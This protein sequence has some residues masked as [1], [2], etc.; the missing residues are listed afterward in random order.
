MH[1]NNIINKSFW[2]HQILSIKLQNLWNQN[3]ITQQEIDIKRHSMMYFHTMFDVN[4]HE[5]TRKLNV[6]TNTIRW[7]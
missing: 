6:C 7:F 4:K 2:Q 3:T 5:E 1:L